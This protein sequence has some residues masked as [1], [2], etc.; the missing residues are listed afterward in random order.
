MAIAPSAD[1]NEH[2]SLRFVIPKWISLFQRTGFGHNA[3]DKTCAEEELPQYTVA[4]QNGVMVPFPGSTEGEVMQIFRGAAWHV[5][6]VR[7]AGEVWLTKYRMMLKPERWIPGITDFD[8]DVHLPWGV[9]E[10]C[11]LRSAYSRVCSQDGYSSRDVLELRCKDLRVLHL[12][13]HDGGNLT[14]L[15]LEINK[16]IRKTR[17]CELSMLFVEKAKAKPKLCGLEFFSWEN[18]F[19]RL[20]LDANWRAF[21]L[22]ATYDICDSYPSKW[23]V[24]ANISDE[25]V[26]KAA[27]FRKRRRLPLPTWRH[28]Q[29]GS[30]LLR[31]AQPDLR[32]KVVFR[33]RSDERAIADRE[34]MM[35]AL[36]AAG[37]GA[38]LAIFDCRDDLAANAAGTEHP[39]WYRQPDEA[40]NG[41]LPDMLTLELG[42][43]QAMY[44]S[45]QAFSALI[46]G[47]CPETE[48][49]ERLGRTRWLDHCR[50]ITEAA[51]QVARHLHNTDEAPTPIV[52][53][54][55][56]T[57][58]WDRT[59]QVCSLAQLLLDPYYRTAKGFCTLIEKD[60]LCFGHQFSVRAERRQ[61]VFLQF[62][63]CVAAVVIQFP[64]HFGFDQADLRLL[65][66]L[67]LSG[68]TGSLR[69]NNERERRKDDS[70]HVSLWSVWLA[71]LL[72]DHKTSA[73]SAKAA[74]LSNTDAPQRLRPITS[75]KHF[76]LWQDWA[77]RY[78]GVVMEQQRLAQRQYNLVQAWP[79]EIVWYLPTGTA[80]ACH[81]C[82][83]EFSCT[84]WRHHCRACGHI[85]CS[86]TTC[87]TWAPHLPEM[88]FKLPVH[89]CRRCEL[90]KHS[91]R[92]ATSRSGCS[93][94]VLA[95]PHHCF[96]YLPRCLP[97][98]VAYRLASGAAT[99]R[100]SAPMSPAKSL[101]TP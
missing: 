79:P 34:L 31:S 64:T 99:S 95:G 83:R 59:P 4:L 12:Q 81:H 73:A 49:L 41:L 22:N 20:G 23:W 62:L 7:C 35:A 44:S 43:I 77:L 80:A 21:E 50:R 28:T 93:S 1:K 76:Q 32:K 78:D 9:V 14:H 96:V 70:Y 27:E 26:K 15:D 16:H 11:I 94:F 5:S 6:G 66:D 36:H 85:F 17:N 65:A 89:I 10:S 68:W 71:T 24:P 100:G 84:R 56:C 67:W 82:L 98:S 90:A 47:G 72:R 46:E 97:C 18:E 51:S 29:R 25:T 38:R 86:A 91:A 58:G 2:Q 60:W 92:R 45:W 55:H 40:G 63:F 8:L 54:V 30:V 75:L 42:N 61:P 37:D 101:L 53:L 57:D 39:D 87:L 52:M 74:G 69:G 88:G 13:L 19:E 3:D 33:Q 48:W